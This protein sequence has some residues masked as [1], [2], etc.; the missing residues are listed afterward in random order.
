M[1]QSDIGCSSNAYAT[2]NARVGTKARQ[3]GRFLCFSRPPKLQAPK[4]ALPVLCSSTAVTHQLWRTELAICSVKSAP[5]WHNRALTHLSVRSLEPLSAILQSSL[6]CEPS[7]TS[8]R[9]ALDVKTRAPVP[10]HNLTASRTCQ[11]RFMLKT[12]S[13]DWTGGARL[14]GV[15]K[16]QPGVYGVGGVALGVSLGCPMVARLGQSRVARQG[17]SDW[18]CLRVTA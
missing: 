7:S 2:D 17:V 14:R 6:Q 11:H 10:S 8:Y 9:P 15:L 3:T 12:A 13:M 4:Q 16:V 1:L 18:R 5:F